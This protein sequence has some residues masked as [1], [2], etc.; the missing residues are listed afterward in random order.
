MARTELREHMHGENHSQDHWKGV[1]PL[2]MLLCP[3]CSKAFCPDEND[4]ALALV[5]ACLVCE[6]ATV[7]PKVDENALLEGG[8]QKDKH[9]LKSDATRPQPPWRIISTAPRFTL[10]DWTGQITGRRCL[11]T[12]DVST[13]TFGPIEWKFLPN[14]AWTLHSG[15]YRPPAPPWVR[16]N[17]DE[18]I[19]TREAAGGQ[20][21]L[22]AAKNSLPCWNC[23]RH[24]H[25]WDECKRRTVWDQSIGPSSG[26]DASTKEETQAQILKE[27]DKLLARLFAV[28]VGISDGAYC[29]RLLCF[30]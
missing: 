27:G 6:E 15:N 2:H 14:P 8:K 21:Y 16:F 5:T 23:G 9:D 25:T 22:Y 29:N 28:F 1:V 3:K 13:S 20:R 10:P 11:A 26:G 24:G 19:D 30:L 4:K 7:C 18:L 12:I 17:L